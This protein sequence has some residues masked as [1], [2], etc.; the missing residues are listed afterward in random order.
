MSGLLTLLHPA[1]DYNSAATYKSPSYSR[2]QAK[3]TKRRR[4]FKYSIIIGVV[5]LILAGL[6]SALGP[7]EFSKSKT[8][9]ASTEAQSF[10]ASTESDDADIVAVPKIDLADVKD[11]DN[12]N[13][14][15][16]NLA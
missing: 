5:V 14:Y 3:K 7:T 11:Q 1:A 16:E 4:F 13:A 10:L 12:S 6:F 9:T 2:E 8:E 15:E